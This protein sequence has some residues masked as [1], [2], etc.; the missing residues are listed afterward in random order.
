LAAAAA[1]DEETWKQNI[2]R[3]NANPHIYI[4]RYKVHI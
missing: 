1:A 3:Q 4:T 2:L